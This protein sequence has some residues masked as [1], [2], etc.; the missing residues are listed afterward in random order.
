M[1]QKGTGVSDSFEANNFVGHGMSNKVST[2]NNTPNDPKATL[3]KNAADAK[4]SRPISPEGEHQ[5][6]SMENHFRGSKSPD[7][8]PCGGIETQD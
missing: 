4:S 3:T 6:T 1:V 8:S 2:L 7:L 5:A